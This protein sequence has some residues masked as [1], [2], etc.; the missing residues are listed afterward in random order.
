MSGG[1][2]KGFL[3]GRNEKNVA[4]P[5]LF[6]LLSLSLSWNLRVALGWAKFKKDTGTHKGPHPSPV[7]KK[8]ILFFFLLCES[9]LSLHLESHRTTKGKRKRER[10]KSEGKGPSSSPKQFFHWSLW[11]LPCWTLEF[12]ISPGTPLKSMVDSFY[13]F[14][15]N[16]LCIMFILLWFLYPF[17]ATHSLSFRNSSKLLVVMA[18]YCVLQQHFRGFF[19]FPN[20]FSL[21]LMYHSKQHFLKKR[22]MY[23]C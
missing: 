22:K 16:W 3:G 8:I 5:T 9:L 2:V 20:I 15:L 4:F 10:G 19:F 1:K 6:F 23:L 14:S 11:Y 21:V 12:G 17:N 13:Q 7:P 18:P